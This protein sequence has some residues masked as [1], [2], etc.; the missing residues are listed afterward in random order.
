MRN[1]ATDYDVL[2]RLW[3]LSRLDQKPTVD[4]EKEFSRL[5]GRLERR[6]EK[7]LELEEKTVR[8][9]RFLKAA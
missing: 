5:K 7:S 2:K 9:A 8:L 3:E 4:Q 1:Q 6:L